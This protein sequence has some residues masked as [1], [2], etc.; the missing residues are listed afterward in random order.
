METNDFKT[1]RYSNGC[2][3]TNDRRVDKTPPKSPS[4]TSKTTLSSMST[5]VAFSHPFS[6]RCMLGNSVCDDGNKCADN[7]QEFASGF[8]FTESFERQ[9]LLM[10]LRSE[11]TSGTTSTGGKETKSSPVTGDEL[12]YLK[13]GG[14]AQQAKFH[15][16]P[17]EGSTIDWDSGEDDN[18]SLDLTRRSLD[19]IT[20][21]NADNDYG[22]VNSD[23][24]SKVDESVLTKNTY[25]PPPANS[26]ADSADE[27]DDD[28]SDNGCASNS[29]AVTP[30]ASSGT[31]STPSGP[32]KPPYS[33]NALIMMAIRSS[34]ERRQT[35]SG[36][37]EFIVH[38]FPY[39]RDNRQGWQNSIRHNLSLNKC[40]VKVPRHYDD[41]GKGNYWMLDPSADDVYIG[42]TTGKLRRRT[43]TSSAAA[44]AAA[45]AAHHHR[46]RQIYQAAARHPAFMAVA[47]ATAAA[48]G[49]YATGNVGQPF[50]TSL[51]DYSLIGGRPTIPGSSPYHRVVPQVPLLPASY[52]LGTTVGLSFGSR[53]SPSQ[54]PTMTQSL[55]PSSSSSSSI[56]LPPP[57][58]VSSLPGVTHPG[59]THPGMLMPYPMASA[60]LHCSIAD[61]HAGP[62]AIVSGLSTS[63]PHPYYQRDA[64]TLAQRHGASLDT[65]AHIDLATAVGGMFNMEQLAQTGDVSQVS[66]ASHDIKQVTDSVFHQR[67]TH[68]RRQHHHHH[69][70]SFDNLH[71]PYSI[72]SPQPPTSSSPSNAS[73]SAA[74]L[75][76]GITTRHHDAALKDEQSSFRLRFPLYDGGV[77]RS[78]AA[79]FH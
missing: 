70:S 77:C 19:V 72:A 68:H 73:D 36:I 15:V 20:R 12:K 76:N 7:G 18:E 28:M 1:Q 13:F 58:M 46:A 33:Y 39:Y 29:A 75:A 48:S 4:P 62:A 44:S 32:E 10:R 41:P 14:G 25:S 42:G 52:G 22:S 54:P 60:D 31:A 69:Q 16:T 71:P 9:Q 64:L 6:I 11:E 24:V 5:A 63:R 43:T 53:L 23:D 17:T 38:N 67:H 59:V 35:L 65:M 47:A 2:L 56:P 34:P 79:A 26:N 78:T 3:A 51:F 27:A 45:A 40:F 66:L 8:R 61:Y 74:A 30:P 57:S 21:R 37:Y 55:S 49:L 50:S